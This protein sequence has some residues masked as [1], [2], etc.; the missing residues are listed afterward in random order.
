MVL[1][2]FYT[3]IAVLLV[4]VVAVVVVVAVV[5]EAVVVAVVAVVW[6]RRKACGKPPC[7]GYSNLYWTF[8]VPW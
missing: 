5:L 2:G 8:V 4:L 7:L 1:I 3:Q 6:G